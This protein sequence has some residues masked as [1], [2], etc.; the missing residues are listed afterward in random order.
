M[1]I[2]EPI[3]QPFP[4]K[5]IFHRYQAHQQYKATLYLRNNDN[6]SR[7]VKVIKPASPS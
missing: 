2:G 3:F 6:V 4:S 7:R 1:E 5:I